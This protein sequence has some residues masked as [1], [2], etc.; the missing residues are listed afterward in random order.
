MLDAHL[1]QRLH[2]T[3]ETNADAWTNAVRAGRISSRR[4]TDAAILDLVI[5]LAPQR[6][7][8]VGCGEGW[9][10]RALGTRGIAAV[11][12]DGSAALIQQAQA[13]GG[14]TF[15]LLSYEAIIADPEQ[16]HGSYDLIVCN[17]SLLGETLVPLLSALRT[18]LRVDGQLV[19][20]TVHPWSARGDSHYYRDGWRTEHFASFGEDDWQPMPWYFRTLSSWIAS[21]RQARLQVE[22]C[23]EP[24]DPA[25]DQTLSLIIVAHSA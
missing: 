8:D 22:R 25:T 12:V 2:A 13:A 23:I 10:T 6:V 1:E 11:G 7:L 14:A 16:L 4:T 21:C 5:A 18:A 24:A 20:Q 19:V 9:L 15:H 17:F 3:W